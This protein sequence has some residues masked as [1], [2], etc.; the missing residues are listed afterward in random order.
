[1]S[2]HDD[3][4]FVVDDDEQES[5][6][7]LPSSNSSFHEE[8]EGV[9]NEEGTY[10][11]SDGKGGTVMGEEDD[12]D[13]GD[14]E[15]E[16]EAVDDEGDEEEEEE[17]VDDE[18]DEEE[19]EEAVDDEGDEEEEEE[20]VDDEGDEEEGEGDEECYDESEM[21]IDDCSGASAEED[22]KEG[23]KYSVGGTQGDEG[24]EGLNVDECN[25]LEPSC[26]GSAWPSPSESSNVSPP[27]VILDPSVWGSSLSGAVAGS[28]AS[29]VEGPSFPTQLK[30]E[31]PNSTCEQATDISSG[32]VLENTG[33]V[34]SA[35]LLDSSTSA[36]VTPSQSSFS[37]KRPRPKSQNEEAAAAKALLGM[38]KL[39]FPTTRFDGRLKD[40]LAGSA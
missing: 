14:E 23:E 11:E 25:S 9:S 2:F 40:L 28:A 10:E 21:M 12:D 34:R 39:C 27:P 17:A 13:E 1:M 33:Y 24:G 31:V 18:G 37:F 38:F 35:Q 5:S 3:N 6:V 36:G 8:M 20:A 7:E 22:H 26:Q 15:E 30:A 19:E 32:V 4:H 16:E 29:A